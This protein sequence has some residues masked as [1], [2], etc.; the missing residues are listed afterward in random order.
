M[1]FEDADTLAYTLSHVF[2]DDFDW[3]K[4]SDLITAWEQHRFPRINKVIDF[5]TKNGT[6]RKSSPHYYEQAAKN[7]IMWTAF[8]FLGPK[9]ARTGCTP[10]TQRVS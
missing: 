4:L 2:R 3:T 1:A 9:V 8:K 6:L 10:T 5:T 7:W